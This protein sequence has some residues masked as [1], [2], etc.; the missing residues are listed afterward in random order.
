VRRFLALLEYYSRRFF[1]PDNCP[2]GQA[3]ALAIAAFVIVA[4]TGVALLLVYVPLPD[5]IS[6]HAVSGG[7]HFGYGFLLNIHRATAD[8]L[9][10]II[11]IH[12]IRTWAT[13]RFRGPRSRN[14]AKGLAALGLIGLIGWSGYVLH[15]DE[16]AMV[17]AAWG[18]ELLTG[19]DKW[20]ILGWLKLGSLISA[21]I[22]SAG[23]ESDL[24]LR[25]FALHVG[26]GMLLVLLIIWHLKHVTPPR[27][28][29][30]VRAWLVLVVLI[31]LVSQAMPLYSD[32]SRPFNPLALPESTHIDLIITFP[33][34]LYPLLG[35][36]LLSA[37]I[38]IVWLALVL[39]PRLE[40]RKPVVA[41]VDE[42]KCTGCRLCIQDCPYG[43]IS[44]T[45]L[46]EPKRET[47]ATEIA[48]V[49]DAYCNAC[50]IC[51]G[52]CE[53]DAIELPDLLSREIVGRIDLTLNPAAEGRNQPLEGRAE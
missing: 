39:V 12:A 38:V 23:N 37:L 32:I 16:R 11:L 22:F 5:R 53:Y 48:K 19:P 51:V 35:G 50:G 14:W 49:L 45:A 8:F 4:V 21:P 41:C 2:F 47:G 9:V 44:M 29:L 46:S 33:L 34:I 20:P 3:G 26:G 52:A 30:P 13:E 43:A 42:A 10:L 36:S 6:T 18:R 1:G 7:G 28:I 24:L 31:V 17:L 25:F 15:W 27:F 40:P